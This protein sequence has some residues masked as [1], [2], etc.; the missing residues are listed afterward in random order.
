MLVVESWMFPLE[1]M[2]TSEV[3]SEASQ[4]LVLGAPSA[5]VKSSLTTETIRSW[6]LMP[7]TAMLPGCEARPGTG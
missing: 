2:E 4:V 1:V 5:S 3:R 7:E 6:V